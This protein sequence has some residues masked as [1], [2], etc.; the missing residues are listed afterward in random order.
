MSQRI[1]SVCNTQF[2]RRSRMISHRPKLQ[3]S[4]HLVV[5]DFLDSVSTSEFLATDHFSA[6]PRYDMTGAFH[7]DGY[8]ILFRFNN[9]GSMAEQPDQPAY[10]FLLPPRR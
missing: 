6:D 8:V 3:A 9:F 1:E 10:A 7:K 2:N 4:E 5:A